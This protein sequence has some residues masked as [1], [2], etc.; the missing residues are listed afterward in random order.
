MITLEEQNYA[1]SAYTETIKTLN[2]GRSFM[3]PEFS[4]NSAMYVFTTENLGEYIKKLKANGK[5]VL[6]VT[7][8]GDQLINLAL[9]GVRRVDNFDINQNAYFIT[10]LKLAALKVLSY[11]EYLNFFC[12]SDDE[13]LQR[14]GLIYF[15]KKIGLNEN[16]LDFKTYLKVKP[17]LPEMCA[18]YWDLLY[19]EF[20]FDGKNLAM[21]P[22]FYPGT[23]RGA[24]E[25]NTYLKNAENCALARDRIGHVEI[26]FMERNLLEIHTLEDT[27]DV[28]LLSNIYDY[29]TDEWYS[30]ISTDEFNQ[31]IEGKM[32][33]CLNDG[34]KIAVAYQYNYQ[35]KDYENS[36]LIKRILKQN[37]KLE[38][39]PPLEHMR[40][41]VVTSTVK[42]YAKDG[43][44]DCVYLYEKGKTK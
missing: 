27:Y 40:K 38:R 34:G 29:L 43:N 36:S 35:V 13:E 30:V 18:F 26:N 33:K 37:Y 25:T 6:T 44:K 19:E 23:K 1:Y 28:I 5:K 15:R 2:K 31:Y 9:E 7:G 8:S 17:Y 3:H 41:I 4:K 42:E 10:Q 11:E 24:I 16:V 32:A 21:S 20:Q 14:E 39:R 22:L 12:I